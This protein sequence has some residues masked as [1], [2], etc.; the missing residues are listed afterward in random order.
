MTRNEYDVDVCYDNETKEFDWDMYQYLC[1][2]A[3]YADCEE[4]VKEVV[5]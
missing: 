1:D 5:L 3:D 2:I 4:Q